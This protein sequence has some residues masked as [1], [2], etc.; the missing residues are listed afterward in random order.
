MD[1]PVLKNLSS[2]AP[3]TWAHSLNLANMVEIAENSIGANAQLARVGAYY[4][5]IGKAAEPRYFV[6]NQEGGSNLHDKLDPDVS[7][8]AI[9][10]HVLDGHKLARKHR[11]PEA[12]LESI[13]TH[14]GDGVLEYFWHKN[15]QAGNP[16]ALEEAGFRYPGVKA[17]SRETGILSICD[18]IEAASRTLD[19]GSE[20]SIRQLVERIVL[21]KIRQGMLSDC[22]LTLDELKR[23]IDSVVETLRSAQHGR[24]KYPWQGRADATTRPGGE[25]DEGD[26]DGDE[27][28]RVR[29]RPMGVPVDTER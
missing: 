3:G 17:P 2:R 13:Y 29:T 9:F 4:H 12:I 6:E 14:H 10:A 26:E 28:I 27:R 19:D 11:L 8:D 21:A 23:V 25:D 18:S 15:Q 5:D 20:Q 16:K 22:G 1:S 24:V 7:A